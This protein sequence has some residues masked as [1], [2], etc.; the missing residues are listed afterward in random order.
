MEAAFAWLGHIADWIGQWFP[1]WV[2]VDTTEGWVKWVR[3]SRVV[4]GTA[5][6]V[7]Y[8][9]V[10]TRIKTFA[11]VRDSINCKPQTV[12]LA[13]GETLLLEV[14]VIYEVSDIERLVA[15]TAEPFSTIVDLAMGAVLF[16]VEGYESWDAIREAS[17]RPPRARDS[18][19]NYELREE[20]RKALEP[21]GVKVLEVQL[22]NKAKCRVLKLANSQD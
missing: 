13:N 4:T 16:V 20:T 15:F 14:V 3:G 8:W 12:T 19:F 17:K 10:T 18:K 1:R 21:Y 9:P 2:I 22:Q 6:I 11:V 7:W 5:G